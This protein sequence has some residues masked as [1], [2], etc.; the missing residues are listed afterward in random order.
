MA[1]LVWMTSL[2]L[3][4]V[5][6]WGAFR[7]IAGHWARLGALLPFGV[8]LHIAL[9]RWTLP[10]VASLA[11]AAPIIVGLAGRGKPHRMRT[12]TRRYALTAIGGF[13]WALV[14]VYQLHVAMSSLIP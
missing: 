10:V 2:V 3:V 14:A 11:M 5:L 7:M 13:V 1:T 9:A 6:D 8:R 4:Q 12:W